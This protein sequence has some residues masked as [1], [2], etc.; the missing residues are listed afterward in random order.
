[1]T[2]IPLKKELLYTE[3][4]YSFEIWQSILMV[5]I[6]FLIWNVPHIFSAEFIF[7]VSIFILFEF[8][9][10]HSGAFMSALYPLGCLVLPF[11]GVF[12]WA[13]N[14]IAPGN[15]ILIYFLLTLLMRSRSIFAVNSGSLV[16]KSMFRS[17]GSL[18]L[19]FVVIPLT[20]TICSV[21]PVW[22]LTKEFLDSIDYY[23]VDTSQGDIE[24]YHIIM[25][26]F[27]Y[28]LCQIRLEWWLIKKGI[29]WEEEELA[30]AEK[31]LAHS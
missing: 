27:I 4:L 6:C 14:K 21:I 30:K 22:G 31:E 16:G 19:L 5:V 29:E 3:A 18:L 12:V 11:Y 28:Y 26:G 17:V 15:S 23:S 8:I 24:I 25:F 9:L 10:L 13:F 20:I 1:M 2:S 7:T